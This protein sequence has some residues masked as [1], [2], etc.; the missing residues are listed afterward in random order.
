[1][2]LSARDK[3]ALESLDAGFRAYAETTRD[4]G[5]ASLLIV[6]IGLIVVW[7]GYI[8][9]ARSAWLVMF[10]IVWMW[11]FPLLALPM[12]KGTWNLTFSE[13]LYDAIYQP[14][15]TRIW[16]ESVLIFLL[17]LIALLLPI[18]SFFLAKEVSEPSPRFFA[19]SAMGVVVALLALLAWVHLSVYEIPLD[20][21]DPTR[22]LLPLPPPPAPPNSQLPCEGQQQVP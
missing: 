8:N 21:L 13:W 6:L 2:A 17:M 14:G 22:Q 1:M 16:A 12:F 3:I 11:A 18:R 9:G 20:Q 7:T 19:F 15:L 4:L 5:V 10:L